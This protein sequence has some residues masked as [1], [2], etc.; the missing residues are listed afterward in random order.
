MSHVTEYLDQHADAQHF[1]HRSSRL[2][3]AYQAKKAKRTT[4]ASTESAHVLTRSATGT[5]S[6]KDMCF[7]CAQS[8]IGCDKAEIRQ[9]TI[10]REF[11]KA[12]RES[13]KKRENNI[14]SLE[15][16][17]QLEGINDFF[18][19]RMPLIIFYA[20]PDF[21]RVFHTHRGNSLMDDH[22]TL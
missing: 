18:L 9:V 12:V 19:R 22:Q 10:G 16:L 5:F 8:V 14:W 15:V 17:G 20:K 21:H 4:A 11:D 1:V 7:Y 2:K 13:V 6:F 3:I